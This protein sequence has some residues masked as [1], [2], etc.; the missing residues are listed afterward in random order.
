MP[1]ITLSEPQ[2]RDYSLVGPSSGAAVERGLV[3]GDW[4]RSPIPVERL[5]ELAQRTD[6]PALRDT[7]IWLGL[8]VASG[9][10]GVLLWGSWWCVPCFAVY[11]VLY[12]SGG[13]SRWHECGH[14]TA[15]RT[16]WMND[17]VYQIA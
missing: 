16:K 11:G 15:F 6:G 12:G 14:S 5:K 1:S 9:A 13:D 3:G 4:Y 2:D 8:L 17:T 7:A 10:G